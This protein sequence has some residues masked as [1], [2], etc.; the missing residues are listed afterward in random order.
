MLSNSDHQS[1]R[2]F[3]VTLLAGLVLII[4][5]VHLVRFVYAVTGWRFL[6]TLPGKS[7]PSLLLTG[8]I[9]FLFGGLLFWGFWTGNSR[10][11][12]AA[13]ILIPVYFASQWFEQILS[14]MNGNR[15]ENWSFLAVITLIVILFTYL[16]LSTSKAK[17]FFGELHEPSKKDRR[18]AQP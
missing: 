14:A 8:L 13:R 15:F 18:P 7:P 9:G 11:P 16:T 1:K 6:A 5:I 17:S 3:S 12:T 4:T 2:P 10:A